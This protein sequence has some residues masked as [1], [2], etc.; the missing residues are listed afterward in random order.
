MSS[1]TDI[2][3]SL[4][5]VQIQNTQLHMLASFPGSVYVQE[6]GNEATNIAMC[7]IDS[8]YALE[9]TLVHRKTST[10]IIVVSFLLVSLNVL[11]YLDDFYILT[12][13]TVKHAHRSTTP[14][15]L[16]HCHCCISDV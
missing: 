16:D 10:P 14:T 2:L 7:Y 4:V 13:K 9:P 8:G 1:F 12:S 11:P 15:L 3:C 6:S 5:C